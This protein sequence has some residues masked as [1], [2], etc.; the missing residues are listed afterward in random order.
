M[1]GIERQPLALTSAICFPCNDEWELH[2]S[3]SAIKK[4]EGRPFRSAD[5]HLNDRPPQR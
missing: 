3:G 5:T 2:Y 4:Q 1:F